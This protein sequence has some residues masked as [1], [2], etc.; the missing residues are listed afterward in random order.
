RIGAGRMSEILGP[1]ALAADKFLRTLG[2]YQVAEKAFLDQDPEV[3]AG[4]AAYAAGVNAYLNT[5]TGPLPLEFLILNHTP[6]PWRP[7]DSLVW[8]KMMAWELGQNFREELTRARLAAQLSSKQ[9]AEFL[10]PY[11]GDTPT[12]IDDLPKLASLYADAGLTRFANALP[13]GPPAGIGSNNWVVD[14]SRTVSGK[15]LLAND[16][17]LGLAAP[18]VWYFAHLSIAG[19]NVIGATLPGV[20]AIV[21]GRNDRVAWGFTDTG[22]DVQDLFVEKIDPNNPGRYL[23]PEG[24]QEFVERRE[25]I[26]VKGADPVEITVRQSRHGPVISD[27][28]EIG[29]QEGTVMAL[30]WTALLPGDRTPASARKLMNAENWTGFVD[31]LRDYHLPQQNIVYADVDGNIGFYAPGK[32]PVRRKTNGLTGLAPAPGWDTA[33]DWI[34]F[35]PFDELPQ[36]YNPAG[37][38]IAT[39]NQKIVADDYPHFI[40][41]GWQK[42]YRA[43]RIK[44]LLAAEKAHSFETFKSI[45]ADVTSVVARDLLPVML[46]LSSRTETEAALVAKTLSR[47]KNWDGA[48]TAGAPE[49]LIFAAWYRELTRRV[50]RDELGDLFAG[51][52]KMRPQFIYNVL[53]DADGQSRWCDDRNTKHTESCADVILAALDA[54]LGSLQLEYGQT[55]SDWRWGDAHVAYSEH[56]PFGK[57]RWLSKLFDLT[58][59]SPGGSYTINVG[60]H[61]IR[62]EAPYRSTH[63]VSLRAIYDL[64][65]L[66][67]SQFVHS[68]GQSGNR[69]S[70]LY[71]SFTELWRRGEYVPMTTNRAAYSDQALGTLILEPMPAVANAARPETTVPSKTRDGEKW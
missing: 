24:S 5:R 26:Q 69:L 51:L 63:S 40:T 6:E 54:A 48:M 34:G 22:P 11:P 4:L 20:P 50:Y 67:N 64:S 68:T 66:N 59:P 30:A 53:T 28:A 21:L 38:V 8:M 46:K 58:V 55:L 37:G 15:P 10:P 14:G 27:A 31:A 43:R 18:S 3:R 61:R 52:W 56:R 45:Q 2:V 44:E 65:N 12:L 17:H 16:P 42:P 35:I 13:E 7:E 57:N 19:R 70:P 36:R 49:P 71:D 62:S 33:Y 47:L 60:V 9:I 25:V 39:A 23:T 41:A 32:V 1:P 29:G